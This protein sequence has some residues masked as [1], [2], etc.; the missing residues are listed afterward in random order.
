MMMAEDVSTVRATNKKVDVSRPDSYDIEGQF[1]K[2]PPPSW[3]NPA[4]FFDS[5]NDPIYSKSVRLGFIR[6]VYG[7]LSVQLAVTVAMVLIMCLVPGIRSFVRTAV[8]IQ[9]IAAISSLIL[10]PFI[11]MYKDKH[12]TNLVLLGGFTV[13]E[14]YG[15][16]VMCT[17]FDPFVVLQALVCTG[18]VTFGLTL[19]T[20]Q[21]KRDLTCMGQTLFTLLTVLCLWGFF[22]FF[23]GG[24]GT[25]Y[26]AAGALIFSLFIVFDT[27][28]IIHKYTPDEY[29]AATL[30]L[31]LDVLNLFI[32]ILHLIAKAQKDR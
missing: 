27:A 8:A 1:E 15:V 5:T 3:S 21:S 31:Y 18:A 20:F 17:F 9:I 28:V 13:L 26:A 16:G 22:G 14:S 23:I 10:I 4:S 25:L 6:K 7:L 12:P 19:Y 11:F 24:L 32:H 29:V 30:S 2:S